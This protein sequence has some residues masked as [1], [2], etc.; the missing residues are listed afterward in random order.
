MAQRGMATI[1]SVP[2]ERAVEHRLES[3]LLVQLSHLPA[4]LLPLARATLIH[5][6]ASRLESRHLPKKK[7]LVQNGV[8]GGCS[9]SY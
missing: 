3:P 2:S 8:R 7:S 4:L 5:E 6:L 9:G 1:T